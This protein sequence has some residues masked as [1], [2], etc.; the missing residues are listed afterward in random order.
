[1]KLKILSASYHR[2]GVC[3]VGFTAILF[4]H[5][6]KEEGRQ[7]RVMIASLFDEPGYC[8]VYDVQELDKGNIAFACGN[9][10]R[11]DHYEC[12]LRPL[13]AQWQKDHGSNQVGPFALPDGNGMETAII[14][15]LKD[16]EKALK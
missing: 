7:G 12:A 1:M 11:G 3:G 10:W 13:L 4:Q 6:D 2:N 14:N 15:A 8:A 16:I 9:S 5:T